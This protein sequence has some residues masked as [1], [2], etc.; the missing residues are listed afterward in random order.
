MQDLNAICRGVKVVDWGK[1]GGEEF[2]E[3]GRDPLGT[4]TD[5]RGSACNIDVVVFAR[6]CLTL[7]YRAHPNPVKFYE[8]DAFSFTISGRK[9]G[10]QKS[11][12]QVILNL[13]L[14]AKRLLVFTSILYHSSSLWDFCSVRWKL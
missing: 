3:D 14:V 10:R 7:E 11:N 9:R 1:D 5:M 4:G 8:I 13:N 12:L 2:G 6:I